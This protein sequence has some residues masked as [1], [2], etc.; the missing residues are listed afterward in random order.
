M[1]SSKETIL[2]L[3]L[4]IVW[5]YHQ[6]QKGKGSFPFCS[7][8]LTTWPKSLSLKALSGQDTSTLLLVWSTP[9]R[10]PPEK[11]H[12]RSMVEEGEQNCDLTFLTITEPTDH[13]W[14][15]LHLNSENIKYKEFRSSTLDHMKNRDFSF[16]PNFFFSLFFRF[17]S[18]KVTV[19]F[20]LT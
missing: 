6:R 17:L 15:D 16:L 7:W 8:P 2:I 14:C 4:L 20:G 1:G 18:W 3:S 12:S 11:R 19:T 13:I 5:N 9:W 10:L